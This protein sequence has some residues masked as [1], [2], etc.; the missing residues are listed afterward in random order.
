MDEIENEVTNI[1]SLGSH[2]NLVDIIALGS[3]ATNLGKP[4][5]FVD[6]EL[7]DYD[8]RVLKKDRGLIQ[9]MQTSDASSIH[10]EIQE[11]LIIMKDITAAVMYIHEKSNVHRDLNPKNSIQPSQSF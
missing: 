11:V 2:R 9:A 1:G 4:Y 7:C 10:N 3:F 6:M 8:L 5:F